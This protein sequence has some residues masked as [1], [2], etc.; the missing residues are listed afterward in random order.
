MP[1]PHIAVEASGSIATLLSF[2]LVGIGSLALLEKFIP[3]LPSYVLFMLLGMTV[4]DGNGLV[5]AILVTV[6]GSATGALG[7]FALGW[8]LGPDRAEAIVAR[9][10]KYVFL[11]PAVYERMTNSYRRN[12][13]WVTLTGQIIPTVRIYLALPAGV[14]RLDPR[15]FTIAI[16]IGTL[17]WNT[18]FLCLG[19]ALRGSPYNPVHVGFWASIALFIVEASIILGFSL[20]KKLRARNTIQP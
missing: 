16:V 12:H 6:L 7:W 5:L 2:G 10:G 8:L 9:Y 14:L 3:I 19:Y 17:V 13:F 20:R 18:P 1:S 15:A 4:T 11:K